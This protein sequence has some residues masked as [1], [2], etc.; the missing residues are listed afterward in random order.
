MFEDIILYQLKMELFSKSSNKVSSFSTSKFTCS[1]NIYSAPWK[2]YMIS[3]RAWRALR[4]RDGIYK[5][6]FLNMGSLE[7]CGIVSIFQGENI[8]E[9]YICRYKKKIKH[10]NSIEGWY[11]KCILIQRQHFPTNHHMCALFNKWFL[12]SCHTF[13]FFCNDI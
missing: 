12:L 6:A 3:T 13:N 8:S 1:F 7:H 2:L 5:R 4:T 11:S 10:I 9:I